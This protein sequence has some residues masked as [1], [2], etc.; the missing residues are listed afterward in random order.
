MTRYK[1]I[2]VNDN[3]TYLSTMQRLLQKT[4]YTVLTQCGSIGAFERILA[5]QPDLVILDMQMETP[6][7]GWQILD[8]LRLEPATEL[9]PVIIATGDAQAL[10]GREALLAEKGCSVLLK[11]FSLT[12]L[13]A[14]LDKLLPS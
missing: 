3:E 9:L 2:V 10:A 4:G 5:E 11:P 6:Y 8:L 13:H 1:I 7:A 12:D 14:K